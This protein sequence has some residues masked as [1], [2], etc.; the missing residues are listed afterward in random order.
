M[1][2]KIHYKN[3][4]LFYVDSYI[5]E[6]SGRFNVCTVNFISNIIALYAVIKKIILVQK[7]N[8]DQINCLKI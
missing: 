2:T 3:D 8:D 4:C 1:S 6:N 7:K 5:L